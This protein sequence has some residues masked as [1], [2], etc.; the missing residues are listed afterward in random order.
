M[1]TPR[2]GS[3]LK[4]RTSRNYK[5]VHSRTKL[6]PYCPA[7]FS[8]A[9]LLNRHMRIHADIPL[10]CCDTCEAQFTSDSVLRRHQ[11]R[12][13]ILYNH[14]RRD[15]CVSCVELKIKCDR[16]EPCFKCKARNIP[17]VKPNR[18]VSGHWQDVASSLSVGSCPSPP[19]SLSPF[20]DCPVIAC[21]TPSCGQGA[22][23]S[24]FF[25]TSAFSEN[26]SS[27][28]TSLNGVSN[29]DV[30]HDAM[31]VIASASAS[32]MLESLFSGVFS[33]TS[34]PT[35]S[36]VDEHSWIGMGLKTESAESEFPLAS[37]AQAPG[38]NSFGDL[39]PSSSYT[40]T[41]SRSSPS[42]SGNDIESQHYLDLFFSSF[43]SQIPIVHATTFRSQ[44]KSPVLLSAMQAC[45]ALYVRTRKASTFITTT[46]ASARDA[47][48]QD[49]AKNPTD[50]MDQI[51]LILA[52]VL[53]QTIGLFHQQPE[54]RVSSSIY[55][56]MLVMMIRR[57][58]LISKIS[59]WTPGN[60]TEVPLEHLWS[61]WVMNEMTK[62]AI[63]WS[64]MHD[65]CQGI[66]FAL[67]PSYHASELTLN[68]PC[69]DSLWQAASPTEWFMAL[70]AASPYGSIQSRLI[71]I[72]IPDSLA[73]L[74]ES[75]L[76][77][78]PHPLNPFAHFI[79]IHA[80]LRRLFSACFEGRKVS[81]NGDCQPEEINQEI[82]RLQFALHNWFQSQLVAPETLDASLPGEEPLFIHNVLPF[83]WLGQVALLAYQ[84]GLPPFQPNSP[85]NLKVELR[86]KLVKQWL[87][88]IRA[89]LKS[90]DGAPTLFWDE[91]MKLRL[92]SWQMEFESDFSEDQDGLL[93]FFA[94]S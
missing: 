19:A 47:L 65:C 85:D 11:R 34:S 70:Q 91:L 20:S 6:C 51:Q 60:L 26:P 18:S 17:C 53:L 62:R 42:V 5:H 90:N 89:F 33:A 67:P 61:E 21:D 29:T 58:G 74:E 78:V 71:G 73:A 30:R 88:H 87:K 72:S 80:I 84:E 68:L 7:R 63:L 28:P 12:C 86:F 48:I 25:E 50:S 49:F 8:R 55:H 15:A 31:P 46:L 92:K 22:V 41:E 35:V 79:L 9:S 94:E 16:L 32:D 38:S 36:G 2:A 64:Y 54:Q 81:T 23:P 10:H 27:E 83:Y 52:V 69:E 24:V 14:S 76:L 66:Y 44:V 4:L 45:G 57:T 75:R 82:Q 13:S 59:S 3:L 1:M 40:A 37:M 39:G 77:P 93:G 56:G 43:S